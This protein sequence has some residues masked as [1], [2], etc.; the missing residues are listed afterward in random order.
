V[1][2][3]DEGVTYSTQLKFLKWLCCS[4]LVQRQRMTRHKLRSLVF[5]RNCFACALN[6]QMIC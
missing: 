3:K 2:T 6:I 5:S 4:W 1:A